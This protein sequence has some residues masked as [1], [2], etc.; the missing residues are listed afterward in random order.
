MDLFSELRAWMRNP[1]GI[2][3][4]VTRQVFARAML[5]KSS[6]GLS[7]QR[8]SSREKGRCVSFLFGLNTLKWEESWPWQLY[9][10]YEMASVVHW[11]AC[12]FEVVSLDHPSSPKLASVLQTQLPPATPFPISHKSSVIA[13]GIPLPTFDFQPSIPQLFNLRQVM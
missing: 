6:R 12:P 2:T 8:H 13:L 1:P 4:Q 11:T 3:L 10:E 7:L 5:T 9:T